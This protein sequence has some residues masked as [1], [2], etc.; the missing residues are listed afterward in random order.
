MP[1]PAK[2]ESVPPVT[3]ISPTTK[4]VAASE[5]VKM[6]KALSPAIRELLSSSTVMTMVG[7]V[8]SGEGS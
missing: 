4:S 7:G 6:I 1:A 2:S 3:L 8:V 5:R